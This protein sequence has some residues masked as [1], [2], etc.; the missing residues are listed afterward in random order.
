MK[1][2]C[3]MDIFIKRLRN[4]LK[5]SIY[6][7]ALFIVVT[8]NPS[9]EKGKSRAKSR[10]QYQKKDSLATSSQFLYE[11]YA[12]ADSL[13]DE[14]KTEDALIKYEEIV[15]QNTGPL[16]F[17][18]RLYGLM[19]IANCYFGSSRFEKAGQI[20]NEG[21]SIIRKNDKIDSL[22]LFDFNELRG[23][24]Y[25]HLEEPDSAL[26]CLKLA[27]NIALTHSVEKIRLAHL[28]ESIADVYRFSLSDYI[29]AE[30]FYNKSKTFYEGL[31]NVSKEDLLS[32]YYRLSANYRLKKD[33]EKA[34]NYAFKALALS[35]SDKQLKERWNVHIF[36]LL[37]IIYQKEEDYNKA[38]FYFQ[39]AIHFAQQKND[40]LSLPLFYNNLGGA[41]FFHNDFDKAKFYYKEAL[42]NSQ[43]INNKTVTA[44]ANLNLAELYDAL[45]EVDSSQFF[46]KK[47]LT[48]KKEIYK[49][50]HPEIALA[51]LYYGN[52]FKK[53]N[54]FDSALILYQKVFTEG[55]GAFNNPNTESNPSAEL[56]LKHYNFFNALIQKADVYK[57]KFYLTDHDRNLLSAL[58]CYDLLDSVL[59]MQKIMYDDDYSKMISNKASKEIY[60]EA[61]E[62]CYL[63]HRKKGDNLYI[64]KALKYME[65]AK[66][67]VLWE[68]LKSMAAN[69]RIGTPD[70]LI[71][72]ERLLKSKL[73]FYKNKLRM[74]EEDFSKEENFHKVNDQI[75]KI[76]QNLEQLKKDISIK[77]PSYYNLKYAASAT[78]TSEIKGYCRETSSIFAEYFWGEKEVYAIGIS[79]DST[80]FKKI[81]NKTEL[82]SKLI[83]FQSLIKNEPALPFAENYL[84]IKET[85][86]LLYSKL[87]KPVIHAISVNDDTRH[88]LIIVPDENLCS[89][90]FEAFLTSR[91]EGTNVDFKKMPY[92]LRSFNIK[93]ASSMNI[94]FQPRYNTNTEGKLIGFDHYIS[95]NSK[96]STPVFSQI[97]GSAQELELIK[98]AM[99]F[100]QFFKGETA[101]E[102]NFKLNAPTADILH[103]AVHGVADTINPLNSRLIFNKSSSEED[104]KLYFHELYNLKTN[105]SLVVLSA[106]QTGV[107]R[108][109]KGEGVMSLGRA[110]Q[111]AGASSLITALWEI[112]D[113]SSAKLVGS[114]Y[115]NLSDEKLICSALTKAKLS[116]LEKADE[117]T[118]HPKN[119]A[120][121]VVYGNSEDSVSIESSDPFYIFVAIFL[122]VLVF[123]FL[124]NKGRQV[125]SYFKL[126]FL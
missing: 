11:E 113:R 107:G 51:Y 95:T 67:N 24:N 97:R 59:Y 79:P 15:R 41:Y 10:I 120:G 104:G 122:A 50:K 22:L 121:L 76:S 19:R 118:A 101:T 87:V 77:S 37:A 12:L 125:Q 6:M 40:K 105:A 91:P 114:F 65:K 102:K 9:H 45:G 119:W 111:Y 75:F 73:A 117:I 69:A 84:K 70:S 28:Y 16:N 57:H 55:I 80:I 56:I 42:V 64:E 71:D 82:E 23:K 49:K 52:L 53:L 31:T 126:L 90:P 47:A 7:I 72:K 27:E 48:L 20:L 36:N 4:L 38:I 35:A 98:E 78:S 74:L 83:E 116:Y 123:L 81:G 25:R 124:L 43:Y 44:D 110:F 112:N 39:K 63:L 18:K 30:R 14:S 32:F 85:G 94:F 21:L 62:V 89:V 3:S 108:N 115:E 93:Y 13:F 100:G 106:C 103:L 2:L 29:V 109:L 5:F 96:T 61:I 66:A 33:Y 86:F 26:F 8:C 60:N 92:L 58:V 46:F 99:G 54:R 1:L 34:L 88:S 68:N 17:N